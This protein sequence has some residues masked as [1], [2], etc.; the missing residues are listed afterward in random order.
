M[1]RAI[2]DLER[3]IRALSV[4][5]RRELLDRL[6]DELDAPDEEIASLVR[7][8]VAAVERSDRSL[9]AALER[10]N[11]F[12]EDIERAARETR[13]RVIASGERWPFPLV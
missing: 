4:E 12:D 10:L 11:R 8:F 7:E 9:T 13:A 1:A 5:D 3:D 2:A 6:I